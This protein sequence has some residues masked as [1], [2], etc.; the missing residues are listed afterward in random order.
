M[1]IGN[2]RKCEGTQ[3]LKK[4]TH[5]SKTSCSS[6]RATT[7]LDRR[8]NR[9]D[10]GWQMRRCSDARAA[11]RTPSSPDDAVEFAASKKDR[12]AAATCC[13]C[14]CSSTGAIASTMIARAGHHH[15][16]L[17]QQLH[18]K[19]KPQQFL[20]PITDTQIIFLSALAPSHQSPTDRLPEHPLL[21][22]SFLFPTTFL[23]LIYFSFPNLLSP[24]AFCVFK[25]ASIVVSIRFQR[26]LLES[27]SSCI[28]CKLVSQIDVV[29]SQ[30][31]RR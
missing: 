21:A 24:S 26:S 18:S 3:T 28:W 5:L 12:A 4:L 8:R 7:K 16:R 27:E 23:S 6:A 15:W 22:P 2:I 10:S 25:L 30:G 31:G 20:A 13:C 29:A 14:C 19:T 11:A 1:K 17:P 9:V